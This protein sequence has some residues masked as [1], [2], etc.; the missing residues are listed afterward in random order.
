MCVCVCVCPTKSA[1]SLSVHAYDTIRVYREKR[2]IDRIEVRLH[3]LDTDIEMS[4]TI[5]GDDT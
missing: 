2:T 5:W 4:S 3:D 1:A